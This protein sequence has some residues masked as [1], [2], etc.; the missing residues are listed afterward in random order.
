MKQRVVFI[1]MAVLVVALV[2]SRQTI[3]P[4]S[5]YS[6]KSYVERTNGLIRRGALHYDCFDRQIKLTGRATP[7][8]RKWFSASYLET[9]VELYNRNRELFGHFF[10]VSDCKLIQINPFLRTIRLPF[11]TSL[12]WLGDID[13]SGPGADAAL[14]SSNGRTIL[15]NHASPFAPL[16][17]VRTPV[18]AIENIA[19]NVVHLDFA[20]GPRT[21]AVE[22]HNVGGATVAEQRI[23]EGQ[24]GEARIL[25]HSMPEGR[26]AR[27][28]TGDW[29]YLAAQQPVERSETF[30]FTGERSFEK[31][32]IVRTRNAQQERTYAEEEPLLRWIGG[33]N[34]DEMLTFGE[35]LARSVSNALGQADKNRRKDLVRQFDVQLS[36]DRSLQV[37][38][39]EGLRETATDLM[40]NSA[41]GDPFAASMTVMNGKT[42]EILAAASFPGERDLAD[43]DSLGEGERRSLLVNH[44]FKRHPIGSAGKPFFYAAIASRH[45]YLLDMTIAPHGPVRRPDGGEGQR[46]VFQFFLTRDYRLWPH[47]DRAMDF[48]SALERSCNKYTVELATLALAAPPERNER[49]LTEPLDRV[50]RPQPGVQWPPP[51][52]P[53]TLW[54]GSQALTFPPSLG[55]YM[56]ENWT[57]VP[58]GEHTPAV[59]QPGSLDRIDEAPFIETFGDI[60]GVFTYG[61]IAPNVTEESSE[62]LGRAAL[63][64]SQYDLRV[65]R[66]LIERLGAGEKI[67]AA[68]KINA[69]FQAVSPERVNL[70]LN[71]VTE[72]RTEFV[73]LLLGGSTSLW[74]NFQ[75]AEALSRLVTK[76][77]VEATLVHDLPAHGGQSEPR[78]PRDFP[79]LA[80][81]NESRD[82]VL[83][84]MRRTI[85]GAQGTA[86][87]AA[88]RVTD[89]QQRYRD[90]NVAVFAKTGSPTVV[91]PE[92]KPLAST[93]D[94]LVNRGR[95]FFR[96]GEICTSPDGRTVVPYG[97]RGTPQRA[98]FASALQ[99]AARAV[100]RPMSPRTSARLLGLTDLFHRRRNQLIFPSPEAVRLTETTALPIYVIAGQL[101]LNRDHPIFDPALQADSSAAFIFS[102]VKWRG[103]G[104][105]N[106]AI[107]TP[108]DLRREDS[109]V[110]TVVLYFD[111]G[112]GSPVAVEAA[113]ALIPRLYPLLD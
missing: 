105:D 79:E 31:L 9:D 61:G 14:V 106:E 76:R 35:A 49:R 48:L 10:V 102:I 81:T 95:L 17:E 36:I 30:L 22:V 84:G 54:I 56:N 7:A 42:G 18:S 27:L 32:S 39:D 4:L 60:T 55:R 26:I 23:K 103:A 82:A 19:A 92:A 29:L 110:I 93:L 64:S 101:V 108:D 11:A 12:E 107:P 63:Q 74:T 2:W 88:G 28:E 73:S 100:G 67:D 113:R 58:R 71:H 53:G 86:H 112:P 77:Q 1:A 5:Y 3:A 89:L 50:F 66:P 46:E 44:N 75:L 37:S 72:F 85:L 24:S 96:A 13:Y 52:A 87:I 94:E 65:W 16:R 97:S 45:P 83:R 34:G 8:E 109:R 59:L 91:R 15:I 104:L 20:G 62:K 25:G 111:I 99:R 21:P 90:Y 70:A 41:G 69:A 80:I 78:P 98:A 6:S 38:L 57:P 51:G 33:E 68:W 47:T 43:V 40:A